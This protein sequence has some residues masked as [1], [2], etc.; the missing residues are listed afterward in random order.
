MGLLEPPHMI[1][2]LV[3]ILLVF[4]PGKMPELRR[5][6]GVC[7]RRLRSVTGNGTTAPGAGASAGASVGARRRRGAPVLATNP[8]RG[9]CG[10]RVGLTT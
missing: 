8:L 9:A 4:R 7:L 10:Q 2:V 1:L 3:S 5:A 6:L